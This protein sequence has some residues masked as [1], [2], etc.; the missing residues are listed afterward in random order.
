MKE[1]MLP[2][3]SSLSAPPPSLFVS[4]SISPEVHGRHNEEAELWLRNRLDLINRRGA[5]HLLEWLGR[6]EKHQDVE[7]SFRSW[8]LTWLLQPSVVPYSF[9]PDTFKYFMD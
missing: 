7:V 9:L 2:L 4:L 5:H 8:P 1:N 3:W 6:K